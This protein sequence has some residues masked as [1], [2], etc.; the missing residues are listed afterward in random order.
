MNF[1]VLRKSFWFCNKYLSGSKYSYQLINVQNFFLIFAKISQFFV[2]CENK[3]LMVLL[4]MNWTVTNRPISCDWVIVS[5][6][7]L[8]HNC[9]VAWRIT[10]VSE[11]YWDTEI[12]HT[13]MNQSWKVGRSIYILKSCLR[14][15]RVQILFN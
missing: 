14:G 6:A 12:Y 8:G 5:L 2:L 3:L 11:R 15:P 10:N 13:D 1:K 4:M 7:V 9:Q